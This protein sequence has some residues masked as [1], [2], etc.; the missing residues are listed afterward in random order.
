MSFD[1]H[2]AFNFDGYYTETGSECVTT[3]PSR[4]PDTFHCV[5]LIQFIVKTP[6]SWPRPADEITKCFNS[7]IAR[8]SDL[9]RIGGWKVKRSSK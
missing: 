2:A 7:S 9:W 1:V 5:H 8:W 3:T 6:A 4:C